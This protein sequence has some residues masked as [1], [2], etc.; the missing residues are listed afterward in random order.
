MILSIL[1]HC[2]QLKIYLIFPP[3]DS[4]FTSWLTGH[5]QVL[6]RTTPLP[7]AYGV[8][9]KPQAILQLLHDGHDDVLWIDSDIIVAGDVR[10]AL[11]NLDTR[12]LV[13][14]EEA[15]WTPYG[16]PDGMR[17]RMWGFKVGR[18][19]PFALNSGV[20][21]ATRQHERLLVRWRELLE[22]E[23][24]RAAQHKEW[25]SRPLH[26]VSD[27]DVLTALLASKEFAHVPLKFL[28]RGRDIV[29]F[30]GPYGYTLRERLAHLAGHRPA[31]IHSQGPKPWLW[32]R[33]KRQR[34]SARQ[35]LYDLY[36]ELSPYTLAARKYRMA[37]KEPTLWMS[38]RSLAGATL[39]ALGF[40]YAPL[41]GL[42]VAAVADVVRLLKPYL[43]R[44]KE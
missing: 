35:Y 23:Q 11:A 17:A 16:D 19:L 15:L 6:L 25:H 41:V 7:T 12:T 26:M 38:S 4:A 31:F 39:R 2:P 24:Y 29:Q 21:R 14:T 27:Q 13:L 40:W 34:R 30:F 9:V 18:V 22:S 36:L 1:E 5:P 44:S 10:K 32:E 33:R 37:L 42:P 3:A 8:N 43:P 28:L 20:V